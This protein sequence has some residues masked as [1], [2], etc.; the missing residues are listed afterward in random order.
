MKFGT[1]AL[2]LV[3][4]MCSVMSTA[5]VA[6]GEFSAVL[7][8]IPETRSLRA[9]GPLRESVE[10]TDFGRDRLRTEVEARGKVQSLS[11]AGTLRTTA[12]EGREPRHEGILNEL[13]V[14]APLFGQS[15]T[16]GKK[17][18][19]WG[20][21][22]GFRPL[23]VV[24]QQD[25]RLLYQFT[26]EGIPAIAWEHFTETSAWTVLYANPANGKG[27]EIRDDESVAVRW[28][29]QSGST[30]LH[31]VARFTERQ[32]LQLGAGVNRVLNDAIQV[33]GSVLV[34]QRHERWLNRLVESGGGL[35]PSAYPLY[36]AQYGR[37]WQAAVG[38][39]WT[40]TSGFG[41]MLEAW[42]DGT[43]YTREQWQALAQLA[44]R[45]DALLGVPGVPDSAVRGNLAWNLRYFERPNL[46]RENVLVRL[47]YDGEQWDAALDALFT[48]VD[49]GSVVT[50]TITRQFDRVRWD[51]GVRQFGGPGNS[52]SG[53][54]PD[55]TVAYLAAQVFF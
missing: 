39:T 29:R 49:G 2:R 53:L 31:G 7:R 37:A 30:D 12:L 27:R 13:Y 36:E 44:A 19:G 3:G 11:Y 46:V 45:Q 28:F 51:L 4:A 25:R 23:D 15:F 54:L 9:D 21:G 10:L 8:V 26:L 16:L 14:D 50:A 1:T 24:Q 33:Y 22:F 42:Y 20:V 40:G 35:L 38:G 6:E 43:A 55:R 34:A 41:V 52:A 17:I 5:A 48:P 47:S 18:T 32:R